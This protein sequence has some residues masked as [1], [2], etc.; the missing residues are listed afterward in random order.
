MSEI[1]S[2]QEKLIAFLVTETTIDGACEKAGV[3]ASTYW[4]W[5]QQ[6]NFL[7]EYRWAR[8][9]ILESTI[10]KLQSVSHQAIETLERNLTCENPTAEI[11]AAQIILEQS[12]KGLEMLDVENRIEML[13]LLVKQLEKSDV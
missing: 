11:R 12:I 9:S 3:N 13:E 1:S 8:R 7:R 5:M 6:K 10:A 2:K 4:R